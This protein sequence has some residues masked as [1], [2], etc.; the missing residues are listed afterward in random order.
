MGSYKYIHANE[1]ALY[2][3]DERKKEILQEVRNQPILQRI[4]RPTKLA[5]AKTIGYKAKQGYI[6]VRVRVSK[7]DFRRPRANHAR[8]PSKSGLYYKLSISKE[9]IARNRA[10][11]VYKNMKVIGSYFIIEDGKNKWFEVIMVDNKKGK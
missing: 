9:G 8:R 3:N 4:E 11:K 2:K 1:M 6:I 5:K 10:L 7:G